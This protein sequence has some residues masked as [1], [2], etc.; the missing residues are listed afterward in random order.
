LALSSYTYDFG[1]S[2]ANFRILY[3]DKVAERDLM[4]AFEIT[5]FDLTVLHSLLFALGPVT[6]ARPNNR[7]LKGYF[8]KL[9]QPKP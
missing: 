5:L 7:I 8:D 1:E 3:T 2:E 6:Y 9:C 4:P